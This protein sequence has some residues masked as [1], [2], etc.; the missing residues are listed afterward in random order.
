[1]TAFDI[2]LPQTEGQAEIGNQP[3]NRLEG[4]C[5]GITHRFRNSRLPPVIG[6]C[7]PLQDAGQQSAGCVPMKNTEG[8]ADNT[9]NAV[10]G[11]NRYASDKAGN[12]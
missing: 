11:A 5:I 2:E 7:I 10:T 6:S 9:A 4:T 12:R 3:A 8:A 1:M